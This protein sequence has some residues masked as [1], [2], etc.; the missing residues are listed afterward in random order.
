MLK[1]DIIEESSSNYASPVLLVRKK[2]GSFRCCIDYRA[3]NKNTLP[4]IYPL[5]RLE[6]AIDNIS[7]Q[8]GTIYS[9]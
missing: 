9:C 3:L 6:D 2:G 8:G 4:M 1:H 5:P 7:A